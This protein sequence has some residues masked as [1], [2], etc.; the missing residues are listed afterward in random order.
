MRPRVVFDAGPEARDGVA[1]LEH[2]G[3]DAE[4]PRPDRRVLLDAG[5]A[6]A[7]HHG[8]DCVHGPCVQRQRVALQVALEL[9]AEHGRHH[10][11]LRVGRVLCQ[12]RDEPGGDAQFVEPG[13]FGRLLVAVADRRPPDA[14]IQ[15]EDKAPGAGVVPVVPSQEP[16]VRA[17]VRPGHLGLLVEDVGEA[18]EDLVAL[19]PHAH[20]PEVLTRGRELSRVGKVELHVLRAPQDS[21]VDEK[22]EVCALVCHLALEHPSRILVVLVVDDEAECSDARHVAVRQ[23]RILGV[24][25]VAC[26]YVRA[27]RAYPLQEGRVPV[28]GVAPLVGVD[29]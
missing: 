20:R 1:H 28:E 19:L 21:L 2:A 18:R 8:P 6:G 26:A 29:L 7:L 5:R 14:V 22:L 13:L 15:E 17:Q 27:V 3:R 24:A 16:P 4:L 11:D 9:R 10:H 25:V 23:N 12:E